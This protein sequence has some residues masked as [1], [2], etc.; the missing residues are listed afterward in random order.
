MTVPAVLDDRIRAIAQ[1]Q[2]PDWKPDRDAV[3]PGGNELIG[4]HVDY[5]SSSILSVAID[6]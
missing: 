1:S 2:F 4:G 3:A 5:N 6:K